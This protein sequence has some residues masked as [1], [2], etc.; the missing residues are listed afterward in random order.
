MIAAHDNRFD[1]RDL[2]GRDMGGLPT[3]RCGWTGTSAPRVQQTM[4]DAFRMTCSDR[5]RTTGR[6]GEPARRLG[7]GVSTVDSQRRGDRHGPTGVR[8]ASR[9]R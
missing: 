7:S 8:L 1:H 6:L 3:V 9:N 5:G 4:G 2:G